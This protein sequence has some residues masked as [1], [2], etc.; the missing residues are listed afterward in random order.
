MM[1]VEND[2]NPALAP[3][4][5]SKADSQGIDAVPKKGIDVMWLGSDVKFEYDL[6][7]KFD[8]QEFPTFMEHDQ[9]NSKVPSTALSLLRFD[10]LAMAV[11]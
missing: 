8:I 10:W 2:I 11:C 6:K 4:G 3:D 1:F 5:V 7:E 9:G